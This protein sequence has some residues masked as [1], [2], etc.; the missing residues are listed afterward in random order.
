MPKAMS[1]MKREANVTAASMRDFLPARTSLFL[2]SQ[3]CLPR[4]DMVYNNVGAPIAVHTTKMIKSKGM[5]LHR[6]SASICLAEGSEEPP[7]AT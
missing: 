7:F 3:Y 4:R 6:R 2:L 1:I 5:L